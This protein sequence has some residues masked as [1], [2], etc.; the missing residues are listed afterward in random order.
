[1]VRIFQRADAVV[2]TRG[3]AVFHA[4]KRHAVFHA[5]KRPAV[6][7]AEKRPAVFHAEKRPAVLDARRTDRLY[8]QLIMSVYWIPREEQTLCCMGKGLLCRMK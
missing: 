3:P 1:M 8:K 7:H 2:H 4:E 6:F 5:E